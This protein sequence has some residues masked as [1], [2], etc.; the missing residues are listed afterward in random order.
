MIERQIERGGAK[1]CA[2]PVPGLAVV[3]TGVAAHASEG[4]PGFDITGVLAEDGPLPLPSVSGMDVAIAVNPAGTT[5]RGGVLGQGRV[6]EDRVEVDLVLGA[7]EAR[8]LCAGLLS[9]LET[10]APV[11][12]LRGDAIAASLLRITGFN[13]S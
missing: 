10:G 3:V 2:G 8:G 1:R 5:F 12:E 4:A 6:Y 13:R 11:L 9:Q 7:E